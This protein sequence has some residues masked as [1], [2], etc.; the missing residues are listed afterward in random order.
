MSSYFSIF[1]AHE[2]IITA[3]LSTLTCACCQNLTNNW[4]NSICNTSNRCRCRG[5]TYGSKA[6]TLCL[7][8]CISEWKWMWKVCIVPSSFVFDHL[9]IMS[10]IQRWKWYPFAQDV[11]PDV[12]LGPVTQWKN[13]KVFALHL[14][15][16]QKRPNL[17][18]LVSGL[19]LSKIVPM[20]KDTLFGSSA[21]L[22]P[23][24]TRKKCI[25]SSFLNS[26]ICCVCLHKHAGFGILYMSGIDIFLDMPYDEL[27]SKVIHKLISKLKQLWKI[28]P[29]I[30]MYQ[31]K[32]NTSNK[33]ITPFQGKGLT[34]QMGQYNRILSSRK[35]HRRPFKLSYRFP[36]NVYR[37]TL[38]NI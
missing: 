28:V 38:K 10:K 3:R 15:S 35:K 7:H 21:I 20:R 29:S 4:L 9:T 26:P 37:F 6:N 19:P 30:N 32:G 18:P 24:C 34:G 8:L 1:H 22:I 13:S 23:S 11:L 2:L 5:I 17:R 12:H 33:T 36:E 27:G 25:K 31:R 14:P 16:I